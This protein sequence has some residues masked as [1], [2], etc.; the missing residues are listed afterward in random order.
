M[1]GI[2]EKRKIRNGNT[3]MKKE[4]EMAEALVAIY[5][6]CRPLKKKP[7]TLYKGSLSNPGRTILPESRIIITIGFHFKRI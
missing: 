6:C 2:I 4:N 1:N 7:K 5:P 3:A